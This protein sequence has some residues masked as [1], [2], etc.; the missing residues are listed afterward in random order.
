M[1]MEIIDHG[2]WIRYQPVKPQAGAPHGAIYA[3]READSVDWYDYVRPNF[4][5][6]QPAKP[7][8]Y[9][10]T[11]GEQLVE[12]PPPEPNFK[13]GSVVCNIYHHPHFNRSIVGAATYDPTAV[14]SINQR[15][16]EIVGYEGD[17]PQKDFGGKTYDPKTG[18]L[19]DPPPMPP[20]PKSPD[21]RLDALEK[22]VK[23]LEARKKK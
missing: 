13:P 17:D 4:L 2:V 10:P 18:T 5:L 6:M 7:P 9:H 1:T 22:R 16:I 12:D 21:E 3:R 19:S 8:T 20:A 14:H 11:T 23:A 15:V